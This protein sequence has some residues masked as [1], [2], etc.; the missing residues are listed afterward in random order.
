MSLKK[1]YYISDVNS[2]KIAK[3]ITING[4]SKTLVF[5][6]KQRNGMLVYSTVSP[7]EQGAIESSDFYKNKV[8]QFAKQE[9]SDEKPEEVIDVIV[10]EKVAD[11]AN[12]YKDLA[13]QQ[14][15][16]IDRLRKQLATPPPSGTPLVPSGDQGNPDPSDNPSALL[17]PLQGDNKEGE[18]VPDYKEVTSFAQAKDIL[19]GAPWNVAKTSPSLRS[20]PGLIKK[21]AEL[22]ISFPN[23]PAE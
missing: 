23:L 9:Q 19:L 7:S 16:E 21:A 10:P 5:E 11:K 2:L 22:G 15:E 1:T 14:A 18:Q 13:L 17:V 4:K 20:V 6:S 8:I 3:R 12:P